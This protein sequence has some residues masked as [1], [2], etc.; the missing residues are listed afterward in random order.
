MNGSY[1]EHCCTIDGSYFELIASCSMHNIFKENL[2]VWNNIPNIAIRGVDDQ[3]QL[4]IIKAH[5]N[6]IGLDCIGT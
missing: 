4:R 5:I 3:S 2:E 1:Y 6:T